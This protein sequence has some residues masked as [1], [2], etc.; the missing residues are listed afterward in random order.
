MKTNS[1]NIFD[2]Y[3]DAIIDEFANLQKCSQEEAKRKVLPYKKAIQMIGMYDSSRDIAITV[4]KFMD[5]RWTPEQ[6]EKRIIKLRKGKPS[7]SCSNQNDGSDKTLIAAYHIQVQEKSKDGRKR[8][9]QASCKMGHRIPKTKQRAPRWYAP[10]I[11]HGGKF[12][13]AEIGVAFLAS[14]NR[15]LGNIQNN[16]I[17]LYHI[18]KNGYLVV[19][20]ADGKMVDSVRKVLNHE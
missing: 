10:A 20:G 15:S 14:K 17:H 9:D 6:W 4:K 1:E 19:K 2:L 13:N 12:E 7:N 8:K 11:A 16:D 3:F 5:A 18:G